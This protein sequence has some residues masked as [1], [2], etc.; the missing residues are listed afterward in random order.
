M[1][2]LVAFLFA[3]GTTCWLFVVPAAAHTEF[4]PSTAAPGSNID[5]VLHME[6]ERSDADTM[7]VELVF[8]EDTEIDILDTPTISGWTVISTA[9]PPGVTWKESPGTRE[10]EFPIVI[11]SLPN[12]ERRLQFRVLQTYGNGEI[13][14]WIAD[15]PAGAPEPENPGPILDLVA[16]GP[17]TVPPTV[18]TN[19]TTITTVPSVPTTSTTDT[20]ST[21]VDVVDKA[22]K[23]DD[24][25]SKRLVAT[26][27]VA[28]ALGMGGWLIIRVLRRTP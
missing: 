8:P 25:N 20:K 11:G 23:S 26:V 7:K 16:G 15:W 12:E 5:L 13:E 2:R 24:D 17:G 18:A 3:M 27:I 10:L 22:D 1:R 28:L 19:A 21:V 4:E 9:S 14:R 6:D